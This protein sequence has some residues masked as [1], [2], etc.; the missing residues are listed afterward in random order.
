MS[1]SFD[2]VREQ[3]SF[4]ALFQNSLA[5]VLWADALA[6]PPPLQLLS[7]PYFMLNIPYASCK[8]GVTLARACFSRRSEAYGAVSDDM[9]GFDAQSELSGKLPS[10]GKLRAH[11]DQ[12]LGDSAGRVAAQD[13]RWRLRFSKEVGALGL[14]FSRVDE[15]IELI[16]KNVDSLTKAVSQL[17][18]APQW[19]PPTSNEAS[20]LEA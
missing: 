9:N 11:L 2:K 6:A 1:A 15:K 20:P 10:I 4:H 5:V 14:K 12:Q 13:E 3:L 17:A 16:H 7:V 8:S 18:Q 19:L